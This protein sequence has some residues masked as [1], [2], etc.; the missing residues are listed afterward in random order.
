[1]SFPVACDCQ[2]QCPESCTCYYDSTWNTNIVD[3]SA[4]GGSTLNNAAGSH[5]ASQNL[6]TI[7]G[8]H[9]HNSIPAH[10]PMD[11]TELYLDGN[12]LN[13]LVSHTFIGRR[14][15]RSLY[16]NSSN[17][18]QISNKT[19]NGLNLLTTL[20]LENNF[21]KE[22]NG[23]EFDSLESLRE[24]YLHHNRISV[25]NNRT[26]TPLR[27]LRI[28]RLDYNLLFDYSSFFK[29]NHY[30]LK[31]NALY[32]AENNWP[33]SCSILMQMQV[34][35]IHV[36]DIKNL[37]CSSTNENGIVTANQH[38]VI[39]YVTTSCNQATNF[40][41]QPPTDLSNENRITPDNYDFKQI[42][43]VNDV[44]NNLMLTNDGYYSR[45]NQNQNSL[46]NQ[47]EY[48][49]SI[50]VFVEHLPVF[51]LIVVV[52]VIL[53]FAILLCIFRKDICVWAYSS[54]G[55]RL[56]QRTSNLGYP[57]NIERLYDAFVSFTTQEKDFVNTMVNNLENGPTPYRLSI[58]Y[59]DV[60]VTNYLLKEGLYLKF[61]LN[62]LMQKKFII[63]LFTNKFLFKS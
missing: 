7:T 12:N 23:Y 20:H 62:L 30:N 44:E 37:K 51:L 34:I 41:S 36:K 27:S 28:L 59:R 55:I 6:N 5:L 46:S 33:C 1:M 4:D 16:L 2:M 31:L 21:I 63:Y 19:F 9:L 18:H 13:Q 47:N 24:L 10:I 15:M 58:N 40:F 54:F 8:G 48:N 38:F 43:N 61:L 32:L 50:S 45:I 3:C 26:F 22:L 17:I 25:I 11:V 52:S 35:M 29:F 60:P 39:D 49:R 53:I 14:N 56:F 57:R 42:S